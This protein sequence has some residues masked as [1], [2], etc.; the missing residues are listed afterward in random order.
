[1]T[2]QGTPSQEMPESLASAA[3]A[4]DEASRDAVIR[5]WT[6]IGEEGREKYRI[7]LDRGSARGRRK[8]AALAAGQLLMPYD[9]MWIPSGGGR[10]VS[11][12]YTMNRE[13][14]QH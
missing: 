8:R 13:R 4:L 6:R 3:D 12:Q 5:N 10:L 14:R 2:S 9:M 11:W 1:M 7:Y